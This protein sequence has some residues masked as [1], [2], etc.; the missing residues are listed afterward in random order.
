MSDAKEAPR[1]LDRTGQKGPVDG[2]S[3]KIG[4]DVV[5]L[6]TLGTILALLGIA[7]LVVGSLMH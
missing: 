6:V 4:W 1:P 5:V 7:L 3:S 2:A